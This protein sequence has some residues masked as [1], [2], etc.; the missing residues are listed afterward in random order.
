MGTLLRRLGDLGRFLSIN[1]EHPSDGF[2]SGDAVMISE[3]AQMYGLPLEP[4]S[5]VHYGDSSLR[6]ICLL[7][8]LRP[9]RLL[10]CQIQQNAAR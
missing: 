2:P 1:L 7:K 5:P 4:R 10:H 8:Y 3:Y 9:V 6:V